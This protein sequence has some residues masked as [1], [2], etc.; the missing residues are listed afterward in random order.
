MLKANNQR[1]L[2]ITYTNVATEE[3]HE[4]LGNSTLVEVATIHAKLWEIIKPYQNELIQIHIEKLKTEI[5]ELNNSINTDEKLVE[6]SK[7][8]DLQEIIC[9]KDNYYK[10]IN[11]TAKE[12]KEEMMPLLIN[13]D[14]IVLKNV[15]NFKKFVNKF[16]RIENYKKC[17]QDLNSNSE[18]KKVKYDSRVN[19]D[20]LHKLLISHD[21][22]LEYANKIVKRYDLLKKIIINKYPFI[23]VDEYQDTNFDVIEILE[24][25]SEYVK[26]KETNKNFVIGFFGDPAQ[27][28]Y[29][30]DKSNG[31]K[32]CNYKL[33]SKEY[34]RRSGAEVIDVINKF[35]NDSLKQKSIYKD[36]TGACVKFYSGNSDNIDKF[37]EQTANKLS[38]DNDN[39]LHCFL[40]TNKEIAKKINI[41]NFYDIFSKFSFYKQNFSQLNTELLSKDNTKLGVVPNYIFNILNIL[42][43]KKTPDAFIIDVYS[44]IN[45]ESSIKEYIEFVNI[46]KLIRGN[47]LKELIEEIDEIYLKTESLMFKYFINYN[48]QKENSVNI[49]NSFIKYVSENLRF[50]ENEKDKELLEELLNMDIEEIILWYRYVSDEDMGNVV[51][52]TYHGTKGLEFKNVVIVMTNAFGKTKNFFNSYFS[53]RNNIDKL[54]DNQRKKIE[55]ASN[56]LYVA[57]SRAIQNLYILYIDDITEIKTDLEDIFGEVEE[58]SDL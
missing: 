12:F 3:V 22:M 8:C 40:L 16:F 35:R 47:S 17:L 46:L 51:Y 20:R 49:M 19:V 48:F 57:C 9:I 45:K 36:S 32:E 31:L 24:T 38:I 54:D 52:H 37:I 30:S 25:L 14:Q 29:D 15:E 42:N 41:E 21:T 28:N 13:S 50:E 39:K 33:I 18:G 10:S 44:N 26:Q 55:Q 1:L 53:D 43:Y 11:K 5:E 34:N 27:K 23:F 6:I 4:R 56:L 58:F 7:K 2:C